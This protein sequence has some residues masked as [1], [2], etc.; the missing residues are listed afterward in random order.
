LPAKFN[1][2]FEKTYKDYEDE[3]G[4]EYISVK[5]INPHYGEDYMLYVNAAHYETLE[6]LLKEAAE[7]IRG[8]AD[9]LECSENVG[10]NRLVQEAQ[11]FYE[12]IME[13]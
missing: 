6:N 5:T 8:L 7:I 11:D 10:I 9:E 12:R 2:K 4:I 13:K 3:D 1:L